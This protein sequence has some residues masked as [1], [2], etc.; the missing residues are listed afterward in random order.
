MYLQLE[1]EFGFMVIRTQSKNDKR[2][3]LEKKVRKTLY[4]VLS[5]NQCA[6]EWKTVVGK[7]TRKKQYF[8]PLLRLVFD[9]LH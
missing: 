6:T 9:Y 4:Y 1:Y 8:N 5:Y 7:K 2:L 3:A